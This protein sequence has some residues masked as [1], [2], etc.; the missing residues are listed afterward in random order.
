M[1]PT[2]ID[3]AIKFLASKLPEDQL[4]EFDALMEGGAAEPAMDSARAA[5]GALDSAGRNRIR[6][7]RT[8]RI[9]QDEASRAEMAERFPHA[10]R[11][12]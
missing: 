10:N 7:A 6:A 12:K 5:W 2:Q 4:A 3:T 1:T 8:G 11:L 9:A